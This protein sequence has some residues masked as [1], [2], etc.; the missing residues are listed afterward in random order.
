[1]STKKEIM[2]SAS[3]EVLDQLK[4]SQPV[5][6][7]FTRIQ[8]P[9]L[10]MFSKDIM[11]GKG[12]TM[13]VVSEAGT[14]YIENRTDDLDE[15]G[16][17]IYVKDEIGNTIDG[18]IVYNR[19]KLSYYDE[20][21]EVY[22]SS[23]IYD[24]DDEVVTLFANKKKVHEGTPEEL[25][26]HY[27]VTK[28]GKTVSALRNIRVLYV[29]FAGELYSMEIGGTSMFEF[30]GYVKK[31]TPT[32]AG[33]LTTFFSEAQT[34]GSNDYNKMTFTKARNL[35]QEEAIEALGYVNQIKDAI[36]AEKAF[37][38]KKPEITPSEVVDEDDDEYSAKAIGEAGKKF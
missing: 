21:N 2:V 30:I 16:K 17:N 20:K 7:S 36:N 33:V 9:K 10:G 14:F 19:K 4:N 25:K 6:E 13:K 18:I 15:N 24:T 1:M 32:V 35:T 5:E 34:K 8:L 26:K 38:A 22:V 11:E 37:F 3:Q 28:D 23:P 29:L 12:K 31:T 27:M